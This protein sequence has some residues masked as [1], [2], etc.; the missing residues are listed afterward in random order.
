[1]TEV[2]QEHLQQAVNAVV[3]TIE[4]V[5]ELYT[6]Q[7]EVLKALFEND[8]IF[9]TNSTNSGKTLPVVIYPEILKLLTS[10]G[11]KF[12]KNPKVLFVTALNSLKL[13]LVNS[14]K[15]MGVACE[16]VTTENILQ[17]L[18]S[19]QSVLYISPEVLKSPK[20]TQ[21]LLQ[22]RSMFVLKVVDE[23]HL[24]K[25]S[26]ITPPPPFLCKF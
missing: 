10:Y 22:H 14:T 26:N 9:Y 15:A 24:G 13:S 5:E 19:D 20:I 18:K 23:C 8:N 25:I 17:L 1:M 21:I 16:A 3:N 7:Y 2:T 11:Y 6:S 12:P 4:G